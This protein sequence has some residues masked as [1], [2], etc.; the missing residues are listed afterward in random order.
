VQRVNNNLVKEASTGD[1]LYYVVV[2]FK[3][4]LAQG[5]RDFREYMG[6]KP[7]SLVIV[8]LRASPPG[9]AGRYHPTTDPAMCGFDRLY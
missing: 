6:R 4:L 8:T 2:C 5:K 1:D 7:I 3:I 9:T